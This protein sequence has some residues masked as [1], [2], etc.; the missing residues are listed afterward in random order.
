[1]LNLIV[2]ALRTPDGTVLESKSRHDY[3]EYVD[4]NGKT[5]VID[6]GLDYHRRSANGDEESLCLHD[7][8]PHE[9]QARVL[10]WGSYGKEGDQPISW[11]PIA[12]METDHL[13][14]VLEEC[15]P[16]GVLK[17][18]MIEELIRR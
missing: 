5:Y 16:R 9:I 4:A 14:T 15:N 8:E 3:K 7:D 1:M 11:I 12:D 6:G 13:K 2:N 18:C 17:S 10:T